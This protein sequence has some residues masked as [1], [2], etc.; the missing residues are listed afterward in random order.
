M[1]LVSVVAARRSRNKFWSELDEVLGGRL[2]TFNDVP[3]LKYTHQIIQ[4]SMR[5]YPAAWM[6]GRQ[7]VETVRIGGETIAEGDTLFMSQYAM[8]R[9]SQYFH[10]PNRFIPERFDPDFLKTIPA[11]AYFTFGGGPRICIG[12]NFAMMEAVMI[13]AVIGQRYQL[14]LVS[15]QNV[16]PEPL[17]TLR[18]KGGLKMKVIKR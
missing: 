15:S 17:I 8:H 2:P 7:A 4:E 3:G 14:Q 1:D 9:R 5:L 13:L 16:E 6:I 12:N 11:Y 10:D 18:I